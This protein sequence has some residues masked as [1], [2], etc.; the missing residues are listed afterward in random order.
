MRYLLFIVSSLIVKRGL[1]HSA[2]HMA[3]YECSARCVLYRE[4][5]EEHGSVHLIAKRVKQPPSTV[6]NEVLYSTK[7]LRLQ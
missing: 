3:Y 5:I 4:W 6:Y 2:C 7:L 1:V